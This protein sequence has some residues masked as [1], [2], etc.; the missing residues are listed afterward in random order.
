MPALG[1][2]AVALAKPP[3]DSVWDAAS[4]ETVTLCTN[5]FNVPVVSPVTV[6][7]VDDEAVMSAFWFASNARL[8]SNVVKSLFT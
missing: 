3:N 1:T 4:V 2:A 5:G 7:A 8:V 6:T